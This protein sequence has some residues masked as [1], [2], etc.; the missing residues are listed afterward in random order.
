[1]KQTPMTMAVLVALWSA[2]AL[3]LAQAE[4]VN[5]LTGTSLGFEQKQRRLEELKVDTLMLEEEAKQAEL[6]GRLEL[7]PIKR[8]TEALRLQSDGPVFPPPQGAG[9]PA[10]ATA[11]AGTRRGQRGATHMAP[12]AVAVAAA[13]PSVPSVAA[14]LK[15]GDKRRAVVNFNGQTYTVG[16]GDQIAGQEV[17][18]ITA[19]SVTV[20]GQTL[21]MERRPAVIAVID[22]QPVTGA[23]GAASAQSPGVAQPLLPLLAPLSAATYPDAVPGAGPLPADLPPMR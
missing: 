18:A 12:P 17:S 14:I 11:A 21:Q 15:S 7:A 19:E 9:A 22:R 1:M 20:G 10:R 6:R 8:R 23:Q 13:A 4:G 3:A 16:E 5:P 2:P